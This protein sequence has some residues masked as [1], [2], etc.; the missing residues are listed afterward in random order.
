MLEKQEEGEPLPEPKVPE[1][2]SKPSKRRHS[3][4]GQRGNRYDRRE[5]AVRPKRADSRKT[6]RSQRRSG[7]RS[8][9]R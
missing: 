3:L 5:I 8:S 2:A 7:R 6:K 4:G 1:E 9:R